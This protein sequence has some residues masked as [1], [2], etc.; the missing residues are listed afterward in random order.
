MLPVAVRLKLDP[1]LISLAGLTCGLLAGFLYA[2][3][4][5]INACLAGFICMIAWHVFDGLD[6]QVARATGKMTALGRVLDGICDYGTFIS[7]YLGLGWSLRTQGDTQWGLVLVAGLAHAVQSNF[8]EA[9]RQAYG[10]RLEGKPGLTDQAARTGFIIEE[11][12]DFL[13]NISLHWTRATDV[14]L[15][16]STNKAAAIASYR[17]RVVPA[18]SSWSLLGANART[19]AIFLLCLTPAGAKAYFLWEIIVLTAL[20]IVLDARLRAAERRFVR[21]LMPGTS[22]LP[23]RARQ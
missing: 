16:D 19:L 3:S 18:L 12:Y 21:G 20:L 5:G 14:A 2:H 17:T 9:R 4:P 13:Q 6:G 22:E 11:L 8:Y 7:V 10:R 23:P 15:A 1:N